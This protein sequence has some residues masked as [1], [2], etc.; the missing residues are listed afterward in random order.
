[1][2]AGIIALLACQLVG[3][4]VVRL[5]GLVVPGP[6]VG[7]L[8]FLVVLRWRRPAEDSPLVRAPNLLLQHLQ[9]LFVPAGV[10]IVV[11]LALVRSEALP[12][13]TGL[14]GSWL[15]GLLVTGWL[16]ALLLRAK[17]SRR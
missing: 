10:G 9:L 15:I 5:T 16:T 12:I 2:L 14:W 7:M 13:A 11:H 6:V 17:G 1:M 4:L 3:E 8:L